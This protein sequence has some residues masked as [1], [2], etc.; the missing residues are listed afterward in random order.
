MNAHEIARQTLDTV[1]QDPG[2]WIRLIRRH[3]GLSQEELAQRLRVDVK[4]VGRWERGET[5]PP[6]FLFS[7]IYTAVHGEGEK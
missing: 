5:E 3:Y 1:M 4:T 7:D 2:R 6:A